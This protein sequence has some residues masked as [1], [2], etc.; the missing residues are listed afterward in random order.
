V[1]QL[2]LLIPQFVRPGPPPCT[3]QLRPAL[4]LQ[5]ASTQNGVIPVHAAEFTHVPVELHVCGCV[6]DPHCI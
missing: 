5:E 1:Q 2:S 6:L 3:A 4:A